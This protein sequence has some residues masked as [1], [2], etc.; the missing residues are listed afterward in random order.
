MEKQHDI[1]TFEPTP[2]AIC[3]RLVGSVEQ[4]YISKGRLDVG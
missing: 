2:P 1:D 4:K 3:L